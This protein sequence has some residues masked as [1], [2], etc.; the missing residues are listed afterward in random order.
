MP[1]TAYIGQSVKRVEDRRFLTGEGCYV[2]DIARPNTAHVVFVRSPH[3]HAR[4]V[5]VDAFEALAAD[6]VLAV[7]TGDDTRHLGQFT[8][9]D[10]EY[11]PIVP[12]QPLV[13]FVVVLS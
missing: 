2:D 8:P 5:K 12:P 4:I 3:A 6:G 9:G 13:W 11:K 10:A 1:E 7:F